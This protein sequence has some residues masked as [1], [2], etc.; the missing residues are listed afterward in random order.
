MAQVSSA[1]SVA[2]STSY[3]V[4]TVTGTKTDEAGA[5]PVPDSCYLE[6]AQAQTDMNVVLTGRGDFVEIQGTAETDPF[7][8]EQLAE[9]LDLARSG[10]R[11]LVDLQAEILG[12][13]FQALQQEPTETG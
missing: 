5:D 6:D 12:P 4:I 11:Q 2:L 9:M 7:G 3:T 8:A 10:V 13:D 1:A